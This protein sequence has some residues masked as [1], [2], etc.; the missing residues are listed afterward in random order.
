M[1]GGREDPTPGGDDLPGMGD[2]RSHQSSSAAESTPAQGRE[3]PGDAPL[4]QRLENWAWLLP[5]AGAVLFAS[6]LIRAFAV[7]LRALGAPLIMIYIFG[8]WLVLILAA[9][10]LARADRRADTAALRTRGA[11]LPD[12]PK[13]DLPDEP[14][15]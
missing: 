6:P 9:V 14:Q 4:R 11:P 13:P 3:S 12:G 10:A 8:V 15:T 5:L 1:S 2:A 7:D